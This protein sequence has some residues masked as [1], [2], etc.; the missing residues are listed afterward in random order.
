[1]EDQAI[2]GRVILKKFDALMRNEFAWPWIGTCGRTLS[3][4]YETLADIS[5]MNCFTNFILHKSTTWQCKG[6]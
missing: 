3:T 6:V 5:D 4:Q 1:L 2:N